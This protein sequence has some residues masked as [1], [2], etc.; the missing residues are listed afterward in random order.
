MDEYEREREDALAQDAMSDGE[1]YSAA[2]KQYSY[3]YG[4]E[5][6]EKPWILSPLDTWE[7][8]PFYCGP[9]V[10]HPEDY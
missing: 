6:P 8:N 5:T 4:E 3:A 1:Y 7:R 9:P 10:P 2:V